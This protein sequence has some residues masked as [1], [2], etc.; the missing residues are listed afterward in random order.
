MNCSLTKKT[1]FVT[2]K[3]YDVVIVMLS[4]LLKA[5]LDINELK[6]KIKLILIEFK[7]L[8]S[9]LFFQINFQL[10]KLLF[11]RLTC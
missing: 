6:V 5:R 4:Q 11:S 8:N 2:N 1:N 3:N 7:T 9:L 10:N